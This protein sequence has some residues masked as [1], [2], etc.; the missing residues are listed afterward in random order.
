MGRSRRRAKSHVGQDQ[1]S[2]QLLPVK[3]QV[4]Q[5]PGLCWG[6][7]R[8]QKTLY[9]GIYFLWNLGHKY[10]NVNN[11]QIFGEN[12][13]SFIFTR[14]IYFLICFSIYF[15]CQKLENCNKSSKIY[16]VS[17]Y[18]S[19]FFTWGYFYFDVLFSSTCRLLRIITFINKSPC[20]VFMLSALNL[21]LSKI[22]VV[23]VFPWYITFF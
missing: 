10:F 14:V 21:T 4:L 3:G 7:Q 12:V 22:N 8:S 17:M 18:I 11:P 23:I 16:Y 19:S 6:S 5:D 13:T 20:P 9:L 15:I 2:F 1:I